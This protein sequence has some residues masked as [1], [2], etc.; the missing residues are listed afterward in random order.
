MTEGIPRILIL[1]PAYNEAG[2]I[3]K[4]VSSAKS[5]LPDARV[6]VVDDCSSDT[7][8]QE[9]RQMGAIVVRHPINLGYGVALHTGFIFALR[10][11][12]EVLLQMDGD[13][14]HLASELPKLLEPILSNHAD[15][16]IGSRY[17]NGGCGYDCGI[18]RRIGQRMFEWIALA[19]TSRR[20]TDPTSGF[21]G[22]NIRAV[23]FFSGD[24]YPDDYPDADVL[25]MAHYVGLRVKE[26]AVRMESRSDGRSMHSGVKPFYY[27]MKMLLSM[28]L[29]ILNWGRWR[30]NDSQAD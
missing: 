21:Q 25:M 9:A 28:L 5:A 20:F 1:I 26:V 4:V 2:R 22:M 7:T 3:G 12:C 19:V 6:L 30:K 14:Q 16:V 18:V 15:L 23:K 8:A 27:V 29:V 24:D 11:N 17:L 10:N 13:G